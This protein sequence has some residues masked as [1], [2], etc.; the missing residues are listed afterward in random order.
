MNYPVWQVPAIGGP[1][2]IG[3]ISIFHVLIAWFA[4]GGGLYLPLAERKL[5]AEGREEWI[6]VLVRHSKFFLV[7]T[8]VFGAVSGVG[9]WFAIGLVQPEATSTLIHN[10]V[11]G[12]AIE[13]VFFVIELASAA[14]Y[15]LTW[16]RIS[17]ELHLKVGY[18]YAIS[19]FLT[20][21]IINGILSF[22]LTP[23]QAWLNVAG[24][25]TEAA[26]FWH[27]FFNPTYFPSLIMRAL[28]CASL[29]G[30]YA[31]I[32]YSRV[33]DP[34]LEPH[35]A[36]M[37]RWSAKWLMPMV[38]GLPVTLAWF[39]FAMNPESREILNL[40]MSTIGSGMF[41]VV[42]RVSMLTILTTLTIAGVVYF[43]AYKYPRDL[44]L[45]HAVSLLALGA[46]ATASTEYA[47][48]T[49]RKPFVIQNHMYSNGVRVKDVPSKNQEGYLVKS[50]WSKKDATNMDL[51]RSMFLGQCTACHTE[52]GY[53][54]M[55][56]L[57]QA[58]DEKAIMQLLMMLHKP[59]K[60]SIYVKYMPPLVGSE[61]EIRNLAMY[62]TT[63]SQPKKT[64]QGAVAKR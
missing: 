55:K 22:M 38:L 50:I 39:F 43:F 44:T 29:A 19:S 33:T 34:E 20:L 52:S 64:T 24:T 4:V 60:D 46:V 36:H 45:G 14:V 23:G 48:E 13:W 40:G 15:Y 53:R 5:Y 58:R 31:L 30:I 56:R 54:S 59:E 11:F 17:K 26:K 25:G 3:I 18:L 16:G 12:W 27:A 10:F 35:R 62:L 41:T 37:V 57:L 32:T 9:I 51:G 49:I 6:P 7:L 21:V 28:A 8:G 61:E 63:L 42:T 2:V 1:W 47:R